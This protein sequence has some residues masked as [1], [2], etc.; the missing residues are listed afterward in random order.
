MQK[1]VKNN[2]RFQQSQKELDL[3]ENE[4]IRFLRQTLSLLD[5]LIVSF[6]SIFLKF[7]NFS[8]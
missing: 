6:Y 5:Y 1:Q 7:R 2:G 4:N 3:E 8:R